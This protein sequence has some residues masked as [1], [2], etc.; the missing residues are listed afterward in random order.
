MLDSYDLDYNDTDDVDLD[1]DD[2]SQ[3]LN[4]T[5]SVTD[6]KSELVSNE[7]SSLDVSEANEEIDYVHELSNEV[8]S[9]LG[10]AEASDYTIES[11]TDDFSDLED[12]ETSD[13]L[14]Y[15]TESNTNDFSDLEDTKSLDEINTE[16]AFESEDYSDLDDSV[17]LDDSQDLDN[18]EVINTGRELYRVNPETGEY[19]AKVDCH[20]DGTVHL[21]ESPDS[22]WVQHSHHVYK[23]GNE[24]GGH[25]TDER[26]WEDRIHD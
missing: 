17:F 5:E 8:F 7:L 16:M 12:A 15:I 1:C 9:D 18:P 14:D 19:T 21:Y 10:D 11:D 3:E 22:T 4:D 25:P 26:P 23:D 13:D 6:T 24:I 2:T 20:S